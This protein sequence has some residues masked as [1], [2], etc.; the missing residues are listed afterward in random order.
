M[1]EIPSYSPLTG[2]GVPLSE[3]FGIT[4]DP[5]SEFCQHCKEKGTGRWIIKPIL[6]EHGEKIGEIP[7]REIIFDACRESHEQYLVDRAMSRTFG[8]KIGTVALVAYFSGLFGFP[9][10]SK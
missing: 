9:K 5:G 6:N 1:Q 2:K 7:R 3:C 4:Y 8:G 10:K